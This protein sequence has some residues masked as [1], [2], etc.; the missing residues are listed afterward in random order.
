MPEPRI[1][2]SEDDLVGRLSG[3]D[4][5]AFREI[6]ARNAALVYSV[7]ARILPP[8]K[9]EEVVQ[10]VFLTLWQK[11]ETFDPA[12]GTLRQWLAG[13]AKNRALNEARR[14]R[15]RGEVPD[16]AA[17]A[18]RDDAPEPDEAEWAARR[19][20]AVRAAVDAL[21]DAQRR[22]LSLAFLD[23][24]THEQVA[25]ALG[26][27]LGT[28]KTRIRAALKRLAPVLAALTLVVIVVGVWRRA[29]REDRALVL[30]TSSDVVPR[31]LE[32]SAGA[33]PEAHG[34]FR[35]RAGSRT[36]VLTTSKLPAL[37]DG[38][39]YVAW[40]RHG[41]RWTKLGQVDRGA[42]D[43]ALLVVENDVLTTVPDEV[44]VTRETE[45]TKAPSGAVVIAWP[46]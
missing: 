28:T 16:D 5:T 40:A 26:T 2:T 29:E 35:G 33:P 34:Q 1:H 11:H 44:R 36:A 3:S 18:I 6:Y 22:A 37:G 43:R 30:V 42:E 17:E 45:T 41:D 8:A 31:R 4:E 25:A 23:D 15:T 10:E 12:R 39:R 9:A 7:A 32:P 27:P 46:R 24:L 21:P 14:D 19:Q 13:I 20:A 38:E